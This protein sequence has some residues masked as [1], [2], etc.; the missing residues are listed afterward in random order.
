MPAFCS[1]YFLSCTLQ[2]VCLAA[3]YCLPGGKP[4]PASRLGSC[5]CSKL[6]TYGKINEAWAVS[7]SPTKVRKARGTRLPSLLGTA[8]PRPHAVIAAWLGAVRVSVQFVLYYIVK[9]WLSLQK[10]PPLEESVDFFG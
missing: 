6:G 4:Q 2:G 8:R 1:T 7:C 3:S 10:V 5:L 9:S